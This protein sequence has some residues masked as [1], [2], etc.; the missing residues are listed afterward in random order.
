MQQTRF[1]VGSTMPV[2]SVCNVCCVVVRLVISSPMIRLGYLQPVISKFLLGVATSAPFF[3]SEAMTGLMRLPFK[4]LRCDPR[5]VEHWPDATKYDRR[6][7]VD[8]DCIGLPLEVLCQMDA[9]GMCGI[10]CHAA[11]AAGPFR[12]TA[13]AP[14]TP[15]EHHSRYL[16]AAGMEALLQLVAPSGMYAQMLGVGHHWSQNMPHYDLVA[17]NWSPCLEL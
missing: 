16:Q 9:S 17:T 8:A 10:S 1:A 13:E 4:Q 14:V 2:I 6:N 7:M 5:M 15:G 3:C 12:T 11:G